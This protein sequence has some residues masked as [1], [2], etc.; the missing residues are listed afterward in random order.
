MA[1]RA[2]SL[3]NQTFTEE[4]NG[5]LLITTIGKMVFNEILPESFPYINEPTKKNLEEKTP[6]EYFIEPGT[7][8]KGSY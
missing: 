8:V 4:Q 3:N 5:K 7:D 6:E 1:V 2:S